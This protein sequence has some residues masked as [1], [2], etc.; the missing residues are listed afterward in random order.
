MKHT[1][2]LDYE[3]SSPEDIKK[4]GAFKYAE[5]PDAEILILAIAR[6]DEPVRMW[7]YGDHP[8]D[9][10]A[11]TMLQEAIDSGSPIWAHNAQFEFAV[12]KSMMFRQLGI[13]PPSN[14]QWHCTAALC[15]LAAIPSSLAGAGDFLEIDM[16][17][18]KDG[19]RLINKFCVPQK[20]TKRNGMV[21]RIMPDDDREDFAKFVDYCR[22]DVEAERQIHKALLFVDQPTPGQAPWQADLRMND[23][24]IP[25]NR[26]ALTHASALVEEYLENLL[27]IF[28]K[29][30]AEPLTE[31]SGFVVLPTTG[32]RKIPKVVSL[33]YGFKPSQGEVMKTWLKDRGFTGDDLTADTVDLWLAEPLASKLTPKALIALGTYSLVGSAAIKKINAMLAM[34]CADGFVRGALM[35]YGAER[36]HRWTGKGIQPQ[37]FARPVIGFTELAY[38]CICKGASIKELESLFG[39]LFPIL[40]SCIRHFIQPHDGKELLQADYSAIEARVAPWL[41]EEEKTL[42]LFRKDEP[43]YELMAGKIFGKPTEDVTKDER[44]LGKQAILGCTYN[45]GRPKFR[46]T[47]ESYKFSPSESMVVAY[48]PRHQKFVGAAYAKVKNQIARKFE[49]KGMAVPAKYDNKEFYIR[50]TCT[51]NNWPNINPQTLAEWQHFAFDDLADR[52][53]STWRAENPI[54]VASWR[55]LDDAAKAAILDP[56][57]EHAVG[58]IVMRVV[59]RQ[60]YTALSL[61]LPSGHFLFYPNAS[62]VKNEKRGWG[63][64]IRFW[65]VIPNTGGKWGWCFTYGGKLLENA[66]QATAGDVMRAG[67]LSAEVKGYHP[68]FL[69]HD[70]MLAIKDH[71]DQSHEELCRCLCDMPPWADGLPLAAEGATIPFYKK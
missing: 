28:R 10:A 58:K 66:T 18:D 13:H 21:T 20:P 60:D 26:E 11:I 30:T 52:A 43:I 1:Y 64:Q 54:I 14:E 25:V 48:L 40:I 32:Q 47:C 59:T 50:K 35:I 7:A 36:S 44:F 45:M 51:E 29:Q 22:R 39:D 46:G 68:S 27:P 61:K 38:E 15:R 24:G 5:H 41:V 3:T 19:M 53:V 17:K 57:T 33:E 9:N 31:N 23:R 42:E 56:G 71:P 2:H 63:T 12:S 65:G 49:K 6:D 67:M 8:L 62:V 70:E 69:V 16:P 55:K 4:T 37:N 34:G